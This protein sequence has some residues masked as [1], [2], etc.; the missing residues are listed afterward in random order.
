M[1]IGANNL[2]E[3]MATMKAMLESLIKESEEKKVHINLQEEKIVRL[4]TKLEKRSARSLA[5]SLESER[6]R[7]PPSKVKLSMRRSTQKGL[8]W[9]RCVQNASLHQAL[10]QEG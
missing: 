7:G 5:K 6:K 4:T 8:I 9:G 3:E 1:T 2:E 10:H